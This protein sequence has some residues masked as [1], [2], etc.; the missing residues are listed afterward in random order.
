MA[1]RSIN[2]IARPKRIRRQTPPGAAPGSVVPDPGA[3]RPIVRVIA[4]GPGEFIEKPIASLDELPTL[5]ARHPVTWI[6]ID[7]LGDADVITR[8]GEMFGLHALALEDVVNTHQRPKAEAYD[9][10][11]F[12]V[13]RELMLHGRIT[14]D[15]VSLFFGRNFVVSFQE[16]AGDY[17]DPV[18]ERLRRQSS[19]LRARGADFLAYTLI[20]AVV[21]S[22]FPI[23]EKLGDGL[24][25]I[26]E[27][28]LQ[29]PRAADMSRLHE[30]KRDLFQVRRAAWPLREALNSVVREP[31]AAVTDETR[32]FLRDCVDHT[33]QIIDLVETDREL[34]SDLRDIYLSAVSNRLNQVMKLLT[35]ISTIFIPL[36]FLAGV[37]GM[38]F[39]TDAGPLSMPELL[40][41]HGY[42][43][44]WIVCY[45]IA[46]GLMGL[47]WRLG[48]LRGEGK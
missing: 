25:E 31:H 39:H 45:A 1:R 32:T 15:Q 28:V 6:N 43:A 40:W 30:I 8:L 36:T 48:W 38:N 23:V 17:F 3:P 19:R 34:C 4:Y 22:Y 26:E 29:H 11:L 46:I 12:I 10:H 7:G 27:R 16:R 9:S 14:S 37:Y 24:E 33:V 41:K 18:R 5:L 20:D 42:L 21:D 13:I 35:I 44:F 2:V 47:F